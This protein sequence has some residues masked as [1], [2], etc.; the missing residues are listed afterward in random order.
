MLILSV[1]LA[2]AVAVAIVFA[3][4]ILNGEDAVADNSYVVKA[5]VI[6]VIVGVIN[7]MSPG[8]EELA[9]LS[10]IFLPIML[11]LYVWLAYWWKEEGSEWTEMIPFVVLVILFYFQQRRPQ[12]SYQAHSK[13]LELSVSC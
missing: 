9:W 6:G 1:I 7:Y 3:K 13:V 12:R 8:L 2:L 10:Y 4:R 5:C 11:L